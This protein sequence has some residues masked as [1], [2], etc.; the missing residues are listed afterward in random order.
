MNPG[1]YKIMSSVEETHWWYRGLRDT[2][3]RSLSHP[4]LALPPQP[5]ILDAGCGTGENLRMLNQ[6]LQPQYLGGFDHSSEALDLARAKVPDAD[7][8]VADI[9]DP[10]LNCDQL[11]L[12][13]SLDVIYIPGVASALNGLK[14]LTTA[15]KP[16]GLFMLNLPAYNWLYSRH[17]VAV[18]TSQRFV[19]R[20]IRELFGELG[21]TTIRLSY[22]LCFL[23]PLVV[24]TRLPG[25]LRATPGD[26]EA[27]SDLHSVP[28][29]FTNT[30]LLRVQQAE[31]MLI[32]R[33][34]RLPWGSSIFAVGQKP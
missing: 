19:A 17:D 21:L 18:H 27:R 31:N 9:C 28:G 30:F 5:R 16:G 29:R 4:S 24:L 25:M 20:E 32:A 11:D 6:R 33:G 22:R 3:S 7:L 10:T 8:Y 23:F 15:L 34:T 2:I 1:E 14:R 26:R 13:V 12:V